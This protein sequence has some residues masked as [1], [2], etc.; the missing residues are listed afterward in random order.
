MVSHAARRAL[1]ASPRSARSPPPAGCR[2]EN[3]PTAR[4]HG[5]FGAIPSS[6]LGGIGLG[7]MLARLAPDDQPDLGSGGGAFG[8]TS[9]LTALSRNPVGDVC[10]LRL[11]YIF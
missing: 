4:A 10:S 9:K 11:N 5:R 7:L 8:A 2:S 3:R 6:H 1:T